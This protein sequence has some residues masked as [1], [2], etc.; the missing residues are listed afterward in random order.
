MIFKGYSSLSSSV[1]CSDHWPSSDILRSDRECA[2]CLREVK[3]E[4]PFWRLLRTRCCGSIYHVACLEKPPLI[5]NTSNFCCPH[6][7]KRG[8]FG[9]WAWLKEYRGA[10]DKW[11]LLD[12]ILL[13]WVFSHR[14][15]TYRASKL[16]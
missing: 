16:D 11:N 14:N 9:S 2:I 3:I 8:A 7:G 15:P 10:E 5:K 13:T 12:Y 1:Y 4:L 6:C